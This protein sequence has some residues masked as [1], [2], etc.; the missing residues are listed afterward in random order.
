MS[1]LTK[2]GLNVIK[3][4]EAPKFLETL[5]AI[6]DHEEKRERI[7]STFADIFMNM[8][9]GGEILCQGTL[10]PDTIESV[11]VNGPSQKIK[12]HHNLV[13]R[14][15]PLRNANRL[16][17]PL[18]LLFKD[19]VKSLARLLKFPPEIEQRHP[20]PG[21]GLAIR[22]F[23]EVTDEKL[24]ILR[25]ADHIFIDEL[26]RNKRTILSDRYDMKETFYI[27]LYQE[28]SQ[29]LVALSSD[30]AVGVRGD[31]RFTGYI[32][33]LRAVKTEDYMTAAWCP[34]SSEFLECVSNRITNEVPGIAHVAYS[35]SQKPPSTIEFM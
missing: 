21:P 17:E 35:I 10:Y 1:N 3:L 6:T 29:A 9:G 13:Q 18:R 23:G 32:A 34:L 26:K 14:L 20:F 5:K 11:S 31:E 27:S 24:A 15:Q 7:G 16:I 12:T 2:L 25:Q 8:L 4:E 30:Q 33:Y 28:V 22:I 19:E